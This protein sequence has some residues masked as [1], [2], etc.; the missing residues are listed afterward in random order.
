MGSRKQAL[1]SIGTQAVVLCL[2][3]V[4][5]TESDTVHRDRSRRLLAAV[6]HL[7]PY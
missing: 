1:P 4:T 2:Q 3:Q 5:K 6:R 7:H